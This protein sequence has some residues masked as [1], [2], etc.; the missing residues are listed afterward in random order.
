MDRRKIILDCDPGHDDAAAILLAGKSPAIELIGITVVSGNQT[1]E[2][3]VTNALHVCQHLDIDVPVYAGSPNPLV[4]V[5]PPIADDIHGETGLDGPVFE[6][7]TRSA[8]PGRAAEF[9]ADTL[10]HSDGDITVVTMGPMTNL[11]LAMRLEPA[12]VPKIQE[13][14]LMGGS[15]GHGNVTPAAEFN[16][17]TDAEA[18]Y[19]AFTCGRPITM[20]GLDVTR[21]VLCLPKVV[22][23]MEAIGNRAARLFAD[24]MRFFNATQKRVFGWDGGPLHDPVTIAYLID[25]TVLKVQ[26]MY[27]TIDIRGVDSYGRTNCDSFGYLKREP[28]AS[29]AVDIDVAKFWDIIEAGIRNYG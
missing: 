3:T 17:V 11:A 21:K 24:M 8:H 4:R 18:A 6:P 15:I 29:V 26:Q 2:K 1:I 5:R 25:P 13:I 10:L 23:R 22:D 14:V 9:I 27:A 19:V 7:L 20:V 12:I 16:I 28:N